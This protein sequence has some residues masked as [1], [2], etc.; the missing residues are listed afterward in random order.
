MS[1]FYKSDIHFNILIAIFE[2]I[3]LYLTFRNNGKFGFEFDGRG[4]RICRHDNNDKGYTADNW[5]IKI[6]YRMARQA[7]FEHGETPQIDSIIPD[8]VPKAAIEWYINNIL[9]INDELDFDK[10]V[11]MWEESLSKRHG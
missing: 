8:M 3:G 4:A 7:R 9:E 1:Y 11:S 10:I 5:K 6:A 2:S